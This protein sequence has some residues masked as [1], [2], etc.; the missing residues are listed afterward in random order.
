[1]EDVK[2][3]HFYEGLCESLQ[4]QLA[5]KMVRDHL[6]KY[7]D[8][9][10]ATHKLEKRK[11]IK[12]TWQQMWKEGNTIY[13]SCKLKGVIAK[14]IT[15]AKENELDEESK[16]EDNTGALVIQVPEKMDPE[17]IIHYAQAIKLFSEQTRR[18]F[19]CGSKEHLVLGLSK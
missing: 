7:N 5:H 3:D 12:D 6:S 18:W 2:H 15:M 4:T 10:L 1:M 13:P 8:L 17:F 9:L 11:E 16:C 14:A 19:A